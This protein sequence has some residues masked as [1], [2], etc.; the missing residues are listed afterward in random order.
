MTG[1]FFPI[2]QEALKN[3]SEPT[4]TGTYTDGAR[5][6]E[7]VQALKFWSVVRGMDGMIAKHLTQVNGEGYTPTAQ[8]IGAIR[9]ETLLHFSHGRGSRENE[10]ISLI[11]RF[12]LF[13]T[14]VFRK[15]L[16][17][18]N[19]D[20]QSFESCLRRLTGEQRRGIENAYASLFGT[21]E[22]TLPEC[23][24]EGVKN[25]LRQKYR[26]FA[27]TPESIFQATPEEEAGRYRSKG[28]I[29]FDFFNLGFGFSQY[30][31]E[32]D[33]TK[34]IG[35]KATHFLQRKNHEN[36]FVVNQEDGW[37][38][39]MYRTA[40]SNYVWNSGKHIELKRAIC[41]GFWITLFI[42]SLFFF[43][44]PLAV[45]LN[46]GAFAADSP[47]GFL[48]TFPFAIFTPGVLLAAGIKFLYCEFNPCVRRG[49]NWVLGKLKT[50][51]D[52]DFW[53]KFGEKVFFPFVVWAVVSTGLVVYIGVFVAMSVW[54]NNFVIGVLLAMFVGFYIFYMYYHDR[55]VLPTR[56]PLFGWPVTA[57]LAGK[58]VYDV[59]GPLWVAL[60]WIAGFLFAYFAGIA[61]GAILVAI[62]LG[63]AWVIMRM[64]EFSDKAEKRH[65]EVADAA[66]DRI[67]E[68]YT[69]STRLTL[70]AVVIFGIY[71]VMTYSAGG[72]YL[73]FYLALAFLF[74]ALAYLVLSA[75][76]DPRERYEDSAFA[77]NSVQAIDWVYGRDMF[78]EF[79][80]N[81]AKNEWVRKQKD[82]SYILK[83]VH[84]LFGG[85]YYYPRSLHRLDERGY[86]RL[87]EYAEGLK[88]TSDSPSFREKFVSYFVR[89]IPFSEAD[90][91]I[92]ARKKMWQDFANARKAVYDCSIGRVV[93][94]FVVAGRFI[95]DT[96]AS[97]YTLWKIFNE[98]CPYV[99]KQKTLG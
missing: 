95:A 31:S 53:Q 10:L 88:G 54:W 21:H 2:F 60:K 6:E 16:W 39:W 50:P 13:P 78:K 91:R 80:L 42:W 73:A 69:W 79:C 5:A 23:F 12:E 25:R 37:Y 89:G 49:V 90:R 83:G 81:M 85:G 35:F 14:K 27:V 61:V 32:S 3:T 34:V 22:P 70:V 55:L 57:L 47:V 72:A 75:R 15:V 86:S 29:A 74:F 59:S 41:P 82:P 56:I 38:F 7:M 92:K 65:E 96:V 30:Q 33:D 93:R 97:V 1:D 17:Y 66:L 84:D 8:E 44:S 28:S 26:M 77:L 46:M 64:V 9:R 99:G 43:I 52:K 76:W 71:A 20:F 19:I 48:L 11:A 98:R 58:V 40:R 18:Y 45:F 87:A 94:W 24:T 63:W 36:D 68:I 62:L 67:D 51:V 4:L